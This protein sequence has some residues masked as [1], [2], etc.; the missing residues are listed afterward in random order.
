MKHPKLQGRDPENI[1][2]RTIRHMGVQLELSK[3]LRKSFFSSLSKNGARIKK[4]RFHDFV[5]AVQASIS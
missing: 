4:D 5:E 1:C 2:N 3:G